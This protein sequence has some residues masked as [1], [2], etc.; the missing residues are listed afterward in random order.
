MGRNKMKLLKK[1][2][3]FLLLVQMSLPA[4]AANRNTV[5]AFKQLSGLVGD[6]SGKSASGREHKVNYRLSAG[7]SVLVETWSLS[8]GRESMTLYH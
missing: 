5:Q 2:C 1:C 4:L 3:L 7:G 6:W 8:S